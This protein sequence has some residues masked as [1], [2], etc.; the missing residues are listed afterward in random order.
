VS[1]FQEI[2]FKKKFSPHARTHHT[3]THTHTRARAR[4]RARAHT[5]LILNCIKKYV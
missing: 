1:Y 3:H 4:A 5:K 2:N